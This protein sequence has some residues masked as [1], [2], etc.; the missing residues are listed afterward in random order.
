MELEK[1]IGAP[2]EPP[3][4]FRVK[5]YGADS[6]LPPSLKSYNE[7]FGTELREQL[8]SIHLPGS[9]ED[10]NPYNLPLLWGAKG[11]MRAVDEA[12]RGGF[13]SSERDGGEDD[14]KEASENGE[15]SPSQGLDKSK[16]PAEADDED[17]AFDP[18]S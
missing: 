4:I 17:R 15:V 7:A 6:D 12:A 18:E 16:A 3:L 13:K 14:D 11:G 10:G 9:G 1:T 2:G 8:V 5:P